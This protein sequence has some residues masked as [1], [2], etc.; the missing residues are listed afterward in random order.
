MSRS[1]FPLPNG[2]GGRV[3]FWVSKFSSSTL[4]I[5]YMCTLIFAVGNSALYWK[6]VG[7]RPRLLK[8]CCY[9]YKKPLSP[10]L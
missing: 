10:V 8:G 4:P 1:P 7:T 5:A 3:S 2:Q 6:T 9:L